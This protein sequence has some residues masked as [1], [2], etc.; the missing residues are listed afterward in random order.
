L[1]LL[2]K[3][4]GETLENHTIECIK[5]AKVLLANLPAG[6]PDNAL[7]RDLILALA[8]HDTG[9]AAAGFQMMLNH[10]RKDWGHQR[11]EILSASFASSYGM[12]NEI[13]LAILTH[14]LQIPVEPG[15]PERKRMLQFEEVPLKGIPPS[16]M[17]RRMKTE[18]EENAIA[19]TESWSKVCAEVGLET[20]VPRS[21]PELEVPIYWLERGTNG[22]TRHVDYERRFRAALLRGL[23]M[24]S[25]HLA[26]GHS[27]PP[28]AISI[29]DFEIEAHPK[30]FQSRCGEH[31]GSILLQ[32]PTGAGKTSAALLWA[33]QNQSRNGRLFYVLPNIASIN[34]MYSRLSAIFGSDYVGLLHSRATESLYRMMENR[35]DSFSKGNQKE[36]AE[37]SRFARTIWF[38]IKVSTPHQILRHALRG[39]GWEVMLSEFPGACFVFDEIHAYEPRM[40]GL[41]LATARLLSNFGARICFMSATIPA[42]L[43]RLLLGAIPLTCIQ[44][45][46][47][48]PTDKAVLELKRHKLRIRD[49]TILD[50]VQAL[51]RRAEHGDHVLAVCNTVS[52]AQKLYRAV[53]SSDKLLLHSRF[54]YRDRL[55]IER[56]V[57]NG[58]L[59]RILVATQAI[60]VSLDLDFDCAFLEPAPID[61][62][63]QRLG[64]V[65]RF[66][67][68]PP[69]EVIIFREE[70]SGVSVYTNRDRVNRGVAALERFDVVQESDLIGACDEVYGTE[71][72]AEESLE[73]GRG[74]NHPGLKNFE[75][76]LVAG[77][78]DDWVESVIEQTDRS[79]DLLPFSLRRE[80][81]DFHARNLWAEAEGLL[82]PIQVRSLGYLF[83]KGMV[84]NSSDPWITNCKYDNNVGLSFEDEFDSSII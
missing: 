60:E 3:G 59:P 44:P 15:I 14:H 77:A 66:G 75:N 27:V 10:S 25:D 72:S 29:G 9:K 4:D 56:R 23:L 7:R 11:H 61:A 43:R 76:S 45:D 81:D 31:T 79:L 69:A 22:Q 82:V 34:A 20:T 30:H 47:Q 51:D 37:R 48:Q 16:P 19:F 8:F 67:K 71:Y 63:I 46:P 13:I 24:A 1:T 62:M 2:A 52:S 74:F 21:L 5:V 55:A 18:W 68:R 42:F 39:K 70:V 28:H 12:S 50:D 64:R 36:A 78:S 73:Y 38:P 54:N 33:K 84:D 58:V 83:R 53:K 35:D 49:G 40:V 65:N 26:S 57:T 32:A 80:Y 17:W 6:V 41:T